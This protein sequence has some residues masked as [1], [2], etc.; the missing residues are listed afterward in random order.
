MVKI[1]DIK[2]YD[3]QTVEIAGFI[4]QVRDTKRMQ[5]VLVRD[6]SETVQLS[7]EKND[8]NKAMNETVSALTPE[9]SVIVKG[10]VHV[11]DFVKLN[12]VEIW[13]EEVTLTNLCASPLPIDMNDFIE[14]NRDLRLDWRFL[15]LRRKEH[16]LIF[17][18]QT[19]AE[20]A[21]REFWIKNDFIEIHSPKIMGNPSESGAELFSLDYFGKTAYL[22][23]SPQFYKQ[24]AMASGFEKVFEIGPAFRAENSNTSRHAAE[25]MSIDAEISW[26]E[27]H[28]DVMRLEEE[29]LNYVFTQISVKHGD[30]IKE[31]SGKEIKI[32]T[33]PF[34]R[35]TIE[36]AKDIVKSYG[37]TVP[38]QTKGDL[39]PEAER[40]LGRY[41]MEEFGHEF[42]FITE[43]PSSVR[44][45]YHMRKEGDDSRTKSFDLI[46]DG[47]EVTTGSQREHRYD[48]LC[49]QAEEKGL[50]TESLKSYLD[51][52]AYGCPPHG[53]YGFGL[54]RLMMNLLG[55]SNIREVSFIYRGVDRLYP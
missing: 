24:M 34:P 33:L 27:S 32:P 55:Y 16:Q 10:K 12:G 37:Y 35:I 47:V 15:D 9:S 17:R 14:T 21:M 6:V 39:D 45:F 42:I 41:A 19:T 46:Y 43:Y 48:V 4:K 30:E 1:K 5:F 23:Q 18:V 29:W 51:Y 8:D 22:S 2:N 40:L 36:Q 54:G 11:D 44:P 28:E 25:F 52:F 31:V 7:I 20:M 49:K 53:G 38:P 13:P 50:S 3:G 26:I